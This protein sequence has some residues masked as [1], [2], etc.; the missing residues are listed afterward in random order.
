LDHEIC[1]IIA[2]NWYND[3]KEHQMWVNR[4]LILKSGSSKGA[5]HILS[6]PHCSKRGGIMA[7]KPRHCSF[8]K[9]PEGKDARLFGGD[10][11]ALICEECLFSFLKSL[12]LE[13]P[14]PSSMK[15][16]RSLQLFEDS[17]R[18]RCPSCKTIRSEGVCPS[19]H[20]VLIPLGNAWDILATGYSRLAKDILKKHFPHRSF[21]VQIG[22][23]IEDDVPIRVI[24]A[25]VIGLFHDDEYESAT[26]LLR[27][28][29]GLSDRDRITIY[30]SGSGTG[31]IFR[32]TLHSGRILAIRTLG[33]AHGQAAGILERRARR[34]EAGYHVE[35][36]AMPSPRDIEDLITKA[37]FT[38]FDQSAEPLVAYR[39]A[40]VALF[41]G[42]F[43]KS[44]I[45]LA[46]AMKDE[47]LSPYTANIQAII[48]AEDA[49]GKG[50]LASIEIL[51]RAILHQPSR[52]PGGMVLRYNLARFLEEAGD[53]HA[54][55]ELYAAIFKN[56]QN[57]LDVRLLLG[58]ITPQALALAECRRNINALATAISHWREAMKAFPGMINDLIPAF[59]AILPRCP[60]SLKPYGYIKEDKSFTLFCEGRHHAECDL[61]EN[62]PSL[63]LEVG[64]W[65]L[66]AAEPSS[67]ENAQP[68]ESVGSK[69]SSGRADFMEKWAGM[70]ADSLTQGTL[71]E[72]AEVFF[73][74]IADDSENPLKKIAAIL[75][76]PEQ[77]TIICEML[78][79]MRNL[80]HGISLKDFADVL[81]TW[82][83]AKG[84]EPGDSRDRS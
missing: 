24:D 46:Q 35:S 34:R 26:F 33:L 3:E 47:M 74:F 54:A 51:Q 81:S 31:D 25:Y 62:E 68:V 6:R 49:D 8:C 72:L 64:Q 77:R 28:E 53:L 11:Q 75:E 9:K 69:V 19:C 23:S 71:R 84:K 38:P 83:Y 39:F 73:N 82:A 37:V 32:A 60:V 27:R 41:A 30:C 16:E 5:Y 80:D 42:F 2:H 12:F 55:E 20:Q 29:M 14:N 40:L 65:L 17:M 22:V 78:A 66:G 70:L 36:I 15:R 4:W 18:F 52:D 79:E 59:I 61:A 67:R 58:A 10:V 1:N 44:R 57:F 13:N 21:F 56:D 76:T 48:E 7:K 43:E 45:Y 63:K 50:I